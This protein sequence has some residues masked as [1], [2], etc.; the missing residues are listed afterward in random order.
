MKHERQ[1]LTQLL[2]QF[3]YGSDPIM[4]LHNE[5]APHNATQRKPELG[6]IELPPLDEKGFPKYSGKKRGRKPKERKRKMNPDRPKRKH[7]GYTLF[8]QEVY[9]VVKSE[10]PSLPPKELIS[11]VARRWK[12][13]EMDS[14]TAWKERARQSIDDGETKPTN[15]TGN[16][17][18]VE[19]AATGTHFS[20]PT[21]KDIDTMEVLETR[22]ND[23][24]ENA[25]E[26]GIVSNPPPRG[27]IEEEDDK[28]NHDDLIE[29]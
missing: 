8:M 17:D 5:M 7:T 6:P 4:H 27:I 28:E 25:T 11:I 16:E 29:G 22:D 21:S 24:N 9:P 18:R 14:R 3:C 20:Y 19:T 23:T 13:L 26:T 1:S 2:V 12:D 10:Y 15:T